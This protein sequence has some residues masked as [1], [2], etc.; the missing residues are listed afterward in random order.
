[1]ILHRA[2]AAL[3]RRVA[4]AASSGS[5]SSVAVRAAVASAQGCVTSSTNGVASRSFAE[6]S[7]I[8]S[9]ERRNQRSFS[10]AAAE[11]SDGSPW[12]EFP[13]AP[14]DPIIGLTEVRVS[15]VKFREHI[16]EYKICCASVF[17][18]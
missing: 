8:A 15:R 4:S 14:P 6:S 11:A 3:S 16:I 7:A 18:G 2:A 9:T 5:V 17:S 10:T 13:M 1:M 12:S